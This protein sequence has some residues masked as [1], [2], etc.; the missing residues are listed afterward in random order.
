M[1]GLFNINNVGRDKKLI[2]NQHS[3]DWLHSNFQYASRIIVLNVYWGVFI[4]WTM[5]KAIAAFPSGRLWSLAFK[6]WILG[7]KALLFALTKIDQWLSIV[8]ISYSRE[9]EQSGAQIKAV[10]PENRRDLE[11]ML[12]Y[13]WST[14]CDGSP[15]VNQ[16]WFIVAH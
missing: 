14:V 9:K 13:C 7:E 8:A 12:V 3:C 11:L 2:N 5:D 6:W 16:H 15:T 1:N 10:I 4:V